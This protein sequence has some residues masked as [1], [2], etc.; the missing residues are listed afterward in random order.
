MRPVT[1]ATD[2]RSNTTSGRG[3]VLD[4]AVDDGWPTGGIG[5]FTQN[6]LGGLEE[7][8]HH[9]DRLHAGPLARLSP[10]TP[11]RPLTVSAGLNGGGDPRR[12]FF[13]PGFYPPARWAGP[14]VVTVHDLQ[15]LDRAANPS[16]A[17]T[18]YFRRVLLP[19][20]ARC[21]RILTVSTESRDAI[22]E[23]LGDHSPVVVVGNGVDDNFFTAGASPKQD[24]AP[25]QVRFR[26]TY[27]GNWMPHKR[28]DLL[29]RA[30]TRA[31]RAVPIELSLPP[32]PPPEIRAIATAALDN[33]ATDLTVSIRQPLSP[34]DLAAHV[35]DQDLLVLLS[36]CEG[37]GL[38]PLEAQA[39]RTPALV[40]DFGGAKRRLGPDGAHFVDLAAD[41]RDIAAV[42]TDLAPDQTRLS[43]TVPAGLR[44]AEGYRW[45]D[46]V[47]RVEGA[48]VDLVRRP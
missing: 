28:T 33:P 47:H 36:R 19:L 6:V 48:L 14:K 18:I 42:L 35:A 3:P 32:S 26:L 27:V 24:L 2:G 43:S 45:R 13:S 17:R 9:L 41:A 25:T 23:Q 37:F 4:V 29:V 15:Y 38:T 44:N 11:L 7:L 34:A 21:D 22:Y 20:I 10:L 16:L 31:A 40:A 46:V 30:V 1:T 12:I 39:A 5:T 8:G